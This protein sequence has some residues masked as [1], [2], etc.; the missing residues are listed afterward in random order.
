VLVCLHSSFEL[1]GDVGEKWKDVRE[2]VEVRV[3]VFD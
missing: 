1:E 2:S 3:M